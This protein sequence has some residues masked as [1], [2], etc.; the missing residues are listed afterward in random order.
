MKRIAAAA[1][2]A[3]IVSALAAAPATAAAPSGVRV[4]AVI[5]YESAELDDFGS[6]DD[7][8]QSNVL[9]GVGVGYDLPVSAALSLGVDLEATESEVA[10][11][12]V[13]TLFSTELNARLGRDLY[14]GGRITAAVSDGV[15]VYAKAGYTSVSTTFD[16]T[17]PTFAEVRESDE[18]GVRA[19]A[20]LQF[21]VGRNAYVGAEYR[22]SSYDAELTRH[23]G[24]GTLGFRF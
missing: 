4:E 1:V 7:V 13:S 23:Q 18:G 8:A 17:S 12:E 19:G 9:Y 2:A 20:G 14:V 22:F 21:A 16:F 3:A 6:R 11:R 10:W 24:V 5:G 15:N